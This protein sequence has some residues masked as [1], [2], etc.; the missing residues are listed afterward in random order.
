MF[1]RFVSNMYV[2]HI[3]YCSKSI[4]LFTNGVF[5]IKKSKLARFAFIVTL[6]VNIVALCIFQYSAYESQSVYRDSFI[7]LDLVLHILMIVNVFVEL[8]FFNSQ[9]RGWKKQ[10]I[11]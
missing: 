8:R 6:F 2:H 10:Y 3:I 9:V 5:N 4:N 7:F 1:I 11:L